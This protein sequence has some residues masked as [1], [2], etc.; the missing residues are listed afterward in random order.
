MTTPPTGSGT[1]RSKALE[2]AFE[3]TQ[4]ELGNEPSET[5]A[6]LCED[7]DVTVSEF[8]ARVGDNLRAGRI[9]MVFVADVIP[10]ELMRIT[11]FLNEQMSPAEVFAVEVKQYRAEGTKGR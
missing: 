8:F 7:R 3:A 6:S 1:G 5:L 2:L 9:R 10:D 11:E 4:A